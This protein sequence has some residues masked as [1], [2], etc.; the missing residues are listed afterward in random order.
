[1]NQRICSE[2]LFEV[3]RVHSTRIAPA[4]SR[5]ILACRGDRLLGAD[6]TGRVYMG[7][8]LPQRLP[9]TRKL[10]LQGTYDIPLRCRP[11]RD[12]RNRASFRLPISGEIDPLARFQHTSVWVGSRRID[13]EISYL[14]PLPA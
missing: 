11:L 1:M 5:L 7:R 10:V 3:V 6:Q 9:T 14:G 13:I 2:G 8:L 12:I 4:T